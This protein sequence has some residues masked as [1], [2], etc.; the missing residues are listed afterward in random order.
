MAPGS[1]NGQTLYNPSRSGTLLPQQSWAVTYGDGSGASGLVYADRAVVGEV[2]A[3][4][5]AVEAATSASALFVQDTNSDG[6]MGLAFSGVNQV[7]PTP[8]R[9]FFDTVK[10]SLQK[11]LFTSLLKKNAAGKFDFGFINSSSYTGSIAYT[12]VLTTPK[13]GFW[14]FNATGYSVGSGSVVQKNIPAILDSGTTLFFL[15]SDVVAAYYSKISGAYYSSYF[16]AWILPCTSTPPAFSSVIGGSLATM[17][18]SYVIYGG[19]DQQNNC[20][21]GI[22]ENTG[23]GFSIYGLIFMKSQFVIF[24]QTTSS[25]PRIGF[26]RQQGVVYS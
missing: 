9:T 16:G 10:S 13:P 2:T 11:P 22:Q 23:I 24:D 21:G 6:I 19:V 25:A 26:A 8:Q 18:G 4:R 7:R 3:T 12:N 14:S 20:Y 15:P 1:T 17:P 5:Q